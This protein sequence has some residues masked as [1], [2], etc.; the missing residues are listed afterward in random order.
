[1]SLDNW[2]HFVH[3][4]GAMVWVGGGLTMSFIG[5]RTRSSAN[6][7]AIA[8]FGR[9]LPYVGLRILMPA[10]LVVLVTG[11]WMVLASSEWHFSQFW[12]VLGLGLFLLAFLIGAIY[13]GRVGIQL[14]RAS[15]ASGAGGGDVKALLN[16]W[17]TGY[18]V[19]LIILLVAVWDMVFKPGT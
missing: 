17:L 15:N 14:G 10:V 7:T 6:P 16:R 1:V 19:V 11:V 5:L 3:V 13:L 12:V 9:T 8:E 4:V 2:L 18:W